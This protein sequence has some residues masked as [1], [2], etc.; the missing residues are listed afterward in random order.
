MLKRQCQLTIMGGACAELRHPAKNLRTAWSEKELIIYEDVK[1]KKKALGG[2]LSLYGGCVHTAD[3]HLFKHHV[4]VNIASDVSFKIN[5]LCSPGLQLFTQYS[6][7]SNIVKY[8]NIK[9]LNVI[10]SCDSKLNFQQPLL[11]SSVSHDPQWLLFS[12]HFVLWLLKTV[13]LLHIFVEIIN[14]THV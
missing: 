7:N 3:T 9:Q 1:K 11:Q 14:S 8:Y 13:V 12:K 4:K 10:Y 2:F 6:K 5:I